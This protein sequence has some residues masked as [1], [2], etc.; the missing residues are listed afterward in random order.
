MGKRLSDGQPLFLL[1]TRQ[2][3]DDYPVVDNFG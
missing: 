2:V 1:F 3:F